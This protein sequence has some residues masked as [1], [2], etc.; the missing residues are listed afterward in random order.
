MADAARSVRGGS[1][2][3][4]PLGMTTIHI[5]ISTN[6]AIDSPSTTQTYTM[7]TQVERAVAVADPGDRRVRDRR[8]LVVEPFFGKSVARS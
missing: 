4:D 1:A 7:T 8:V 5:G 2:P 3:A 6:V